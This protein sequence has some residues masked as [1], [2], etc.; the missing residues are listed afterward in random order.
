MNLTIT[1]EPGFVNFSPVGFRQVASDLIRCMD[2]F[3]PVKFS[4]VPYF[5]CCRAIELALKAAHLETQRQDAVK[6]SFGHD[7]FASYHALAASEQTLS[8]PEVE[9]LEKAGE[10]YVSKAF[11]YISPYHAATGFSHFPDLDALKALSKKI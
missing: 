4:I 9:L 7:L 1:P 10:L 11:E 8:R 6:K 2:S 3:E 5:L